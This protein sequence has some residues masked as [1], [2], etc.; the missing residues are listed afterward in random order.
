MSDD[1]S[2]EAFLGMS[3]AS[4]GLHS[5]FQSMIAAGF[6]EQVASRIIGTMLAEI[7]RGEAENQ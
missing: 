1:E 2:L 6:S 4:I 5:L 7:T 3:Q